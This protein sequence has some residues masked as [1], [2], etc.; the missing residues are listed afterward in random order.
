MG[1]A[2]PPL[3]AHRPGNGGKTVHPLGAQLK[4]DSHPR[5]V[6]E[7][8]VPSQGVPVCRVPGL[9]LAARAHGWGGLMNL[10]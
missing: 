3:E 10:F 4:E 9:K 2:R 8:S 7:A 1:E 5:L 6:A